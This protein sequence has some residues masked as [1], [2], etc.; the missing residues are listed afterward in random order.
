MSVI[1]TAGLWWLYFHNHEGTVVRRLPEQEATWKPTAWI[2]SH[3][4]LAM[5][6]VA[7]GI[8]LDFVLTDHTGVAERWI[9][10]G[11]L[12]VAFLSLAMILNVTLNP[13]DPRTKQKAVVRLL[14]IPVVLIV[15]AIAGEVAM[16]VT[17]TI[18]AVLVVAQVAIDL[19]FEPARTGSSEH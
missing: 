15:G 17:A 2:Y 9:L 13:N 1:V 10:A 11:G 19:V 18:V 7:A 14:A 3:L 5:G 4:P 6:M 16:G 8:G 12:T